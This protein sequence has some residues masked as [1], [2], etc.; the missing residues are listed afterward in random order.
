MCFTARRRNFLIE[1]KRLLRAVLERI[2]NIGIID[3]ESIPDHL[4]I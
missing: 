3:Q 4:G 2:A 1:T